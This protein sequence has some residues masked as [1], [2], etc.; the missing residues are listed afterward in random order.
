MHTYIYTYV[1]FKP[2]TNAHLMQSSGIKTA[3]QMDRYVM[4]CCVLCCCAMHYSVVVLYSN[5]YM[6]LTFDE[7]KVK[8][9]L[10]YNKHTGQVVGFTHLG[11]V[12]EDLKKL[13]ERVNG[14]TE[15]PIMATHML[16]FMIRGMYVCTQVKKHSSLHACIITVIFTILHVCRCFH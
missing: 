8:E 15:K 5:R 1:G 11:D 13:E 3:K 10:V 2:E 16:S 7:M 12:N 14:T 6:V 9:G 4:Y